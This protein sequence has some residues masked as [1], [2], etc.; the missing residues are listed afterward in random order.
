MA[1]TVNAQPCAGSDALRAPHIFTLWA[2]SQ[3]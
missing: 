1:G 3:R 2:E